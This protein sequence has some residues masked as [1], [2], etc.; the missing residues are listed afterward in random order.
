MGLELFPDSLLSKLLCEPESPGLGPASH[1]KWSVCP[2]MANPDAESPNLPGAFC[3]ELL[4]H[5]YDS[6][7]LSSSCMPAQR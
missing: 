7:F 5:S 6:V 3:S 4:I 2:S 1:L